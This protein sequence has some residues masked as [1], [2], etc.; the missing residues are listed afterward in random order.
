[1]TGTIVTLAVIFALGLLLVLAVLWA[2]YQTARAN[3]LEARLEEMDEE[4]TLAP[5]PWGRYDLEE[6]NA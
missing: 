1:M 4:L 3:A 5:I 2:L 6:D